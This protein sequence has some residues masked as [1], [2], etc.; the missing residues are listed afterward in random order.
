M[1]NMTLDNGYVV[2]LPLNLGSEHS[3]RQ[4]ERECTV[5]L[6]RKGP[7]E[8]LGNPVTGYVYV[9]PAANAGAGHEPSHYGDRGYWRSARVGWLADAYLSEAG[10]SW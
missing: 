4:Y 6:G 10:R 7:W 8:Y 9:R 1:N 2:R 3:I 5:L